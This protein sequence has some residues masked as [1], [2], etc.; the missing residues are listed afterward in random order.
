MEAVSVRIGFQANS[1]RSFE[2]ETDRWITRMQHGIRPS[3]TLEADIGIARLAKSIDYDDTRKPAC[4]YLD[5]RV[6][7]RSGSACIA[8]GGHSFGNNRSKHV[9]TMSI[10]RVTE[11]VGY[12]RLSVYASP[13]SACTSDSGTGSM[14]RDY[15][16]NIFGAWKQYLIGVLVT[17]SDIGWENG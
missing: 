5:A 7:E 8:S 11:Y 15:C 16:E 1:N 4:L 10:A 17:G 3:C 6:K 13:F 2:I 12:G 9:R 14:C